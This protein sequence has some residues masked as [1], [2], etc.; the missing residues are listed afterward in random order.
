MQLLPGVLDVKGK[1]FEQSM[2]TT[3]MELTKH[4]E[5]IM[6]FRNP[7]LGVRDLDDVPSFIIRSSTYGIIIFHVVDDKISGIYSED[8]EYWE[9]ENTYIYSQDIILD[10]YFQNFKTR[11][12]SNSKLYNRKENALKFEVR[13]Y[14]VF[15]SN[16][17]SEINSIEG[18]VDSLSCEIICADNY[19]EYLGVI[20][21]ETEYSID[22]ELLDLIDS[23]IEGTSVYK[24]FKKER[25]A[26]ALVTKNDFIKKSLDYTWKLD[27]TQRAV[28]MQIPSGPQRIRG[29]AGTGKTIILCMKAANAH[30]TFDDFKILFVFNN[31]SMY[32]QIEKNIQDYYVWETQTT[33]NSDKLQVRHAW[34][35]KNVRGVYSDLCEDLGITPKTFFDVR[36]LPDPNNAIFE[37]ILTNYKDH[38]KPKYDLILVD[39]AQDFSP[40]FFEIIYLL[41]K[42]EKRIVW[43]YDEFQSLKELRIR[44]PEELFGKGLDNEPNLPN[45]VLEGEYSG[46]IQKDFVLP[47]S[48]RNPRINLM[49]AH[50]IGL[51][52]FSENF[53][54]PMPDKKTWEAR[55]YKV[56][57]PDKPKFEKDDQVVIERP[58]SNSRN[59]LERL[60]KE[61]SRDEKELI[62][63]RMFKNKQSEHDAIINE[64]HKLVTEENVEPDEIIV[65]TL[66]TKNS[67]PDFKYIR[68]QLNILNIKCITP[69]FVEESNLFKE[70]GRVTLTT[71][72][73]A[74][75]NESN[76]VFVLNANRVVNDYS[77]R[78]RNAF[79]VSVTRSRGWCYITA[80][81]Q[82]YGID[83]EVNS[84]LNNYP[85]F[86]F[87]FPDMV[88]YHNSIKIMMTSDKQ[89]DMYQREIESKMKDDAYRAVF[90]EMIKN[91]QSLA[92]EI[93]KKLDE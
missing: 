1:P 90:L 41:A 54:I 21:S 3:L 61:N 7:T 27:S 23:L 93:K 49:I 5:G 70:P 17:S 20:F 63:F 72:F 35:G 12:S 65:I 8:D 58:E 87:T 57:S 40:S 55:G 4:D 69:G 2:W 84:I 67:D 77:F 22:I 6:G 88:E 83:H 51:G 43:A 24:K 38:I 66:D 36:H 14:I 26:S 86:S 15:A 52:L 48:Y 29:L 50:G 71:A 74:K 9:T 91:D 53:K 47:N 39:E 92:D 46:R 44:E 13:R 76:I 42:E 19:L 11:L 37:D 80:N 59:I 73:R 82:K 75:G 30:K 45:S 79:F 56:I 68:S 31:L 85:Q 10:N 34:G 60:L 28:A 62:K 78:A 81:L 33:Y 18:L 89:L 25:I 64:I 32:S 16:S